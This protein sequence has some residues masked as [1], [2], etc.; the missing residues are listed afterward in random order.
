MK[1]ELSCTLHVEGR[2]DNEFLDAL[3]EL[4]KNVSLEDPDKLLILHSNDIG[5]VV[6]YINNIDILNATDD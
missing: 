6:G 2:V 5:D 4:F 1:I 3:Q